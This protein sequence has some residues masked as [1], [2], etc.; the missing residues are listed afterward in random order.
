MK[1]TIKEENGQVE[2]WVGHRIEARLSAD[3]PLYIM[4]AKM[5][6][7]HS[8]RP[9]LVERIWKAS[10]YVNAG[11][12]NPPARK[13]WVGEWSRPGF[14]DI[15][16]YLLYEDGNLMACEC[17]DFQRNQAPYLPGKAQRLCSHIIAHLICGKLEA[18]TAERVGV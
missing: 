2:I 1:Y 13:A 3:S 8:E 7:K 9:Q 14:A 10:V 11:S 6:E 5:A 15:G 12:V 17:S 16:G 4:A 18:V